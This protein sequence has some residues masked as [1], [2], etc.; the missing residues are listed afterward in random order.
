[1]GTINSRNPVYRING[2]NFRHERIKLQNML[3]RTVDFLT[4]N[5]GH[6]KAEKG[7]DLLL[8]KIIVLEC[9]F[10]DNDYRLH[11]KNETFKMFAYDAINK[12]R[13]QSF[14]DHLIKGVR[15]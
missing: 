3:D 12:K 9:V 4:V 5:E 1:M 10:L 7:H 6:S 14:F 2:I 8:A 13:L 15:S 11:G